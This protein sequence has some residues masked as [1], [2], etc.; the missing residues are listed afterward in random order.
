MK[1]INNDINIL[2]Y[3]LSS[4]II[5]LLLLL[6]DEMIIINNISCY[7]DQFNNKITSPLC[8]DNNK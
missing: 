2:F 6:F 3:L 7:L 1:V 8:Y 4:I 5:I